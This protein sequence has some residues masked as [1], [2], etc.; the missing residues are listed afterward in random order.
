MKTDPFAQE[1]LEYGK[2]KLLHYF[3]I[4]CDGLR[5]DMRQEL[6]DGIDA[7]FRAAVIQAKLE[8]EQERQEKE[9]F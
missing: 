8:V 4:A 3:A 7:L 9:P 5:S 6:E 1:K 2:D